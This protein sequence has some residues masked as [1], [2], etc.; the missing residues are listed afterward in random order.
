MLKH[1]SS[2]L[3]V[4]VALA[5]TA[6]GGGSGAGG[7]TPAAATGAG[8]ITPAAATGGKV[9]DG[10]L[11]GATVFCDAN[12]NGVFDA[13]ELSTKTDA[14]GNFSFNPGCNDTVVATGGIDA[15]T[16]FPFN[17]TLKSPAG[18]AMTTPVTAL[19]ADGMT[20]AQLTAALGMPAGADAT[21]SDPMLPEN[22]ALLKTT[23]AVQQIVQQ[24]A[25]TFASLA[26][27]TDVSGVYS[28]VGAALAKSLIANPS[29]SLVSADGTVNLIAINAAATDALA[30]LKTDPKFASITISAAD[31]QAATAQIGAQAQRFSTAA[32]DADLTLLAV[33]LQDPVA[34]PIDTKGTVNYLALQNDS[35]RFNG[36]PITYASLTTGAAISTPT[37]IGLDFSIQGS[38]AID[39][40]ANLALELVEVGGQSR[41]LQLMIDKVDIKNNAGQLSIAPS[42]TA[43]V[44]VYG[45]TSNG[46]DINLTLNDLTFKPITVTKNSLTLNYT[47]MVNKVLASVDN[48]TKTTAEK[49]T[50]IS[51]NF[52]ITVAV[53]GGLPIRNLDGASALSTTKVLVK[54]TTQSINGV[55]VSGTLVIQ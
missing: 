24:L 22:R 23:L 52:K 38:P 9:V 20:A 21:K 11:S 14:G 51:G 3:C 30:A 47:S 19:L 41:V 8:G 55:G 1:K 33:N 54:N 18:S 50:N 16:K 25:N 53:G 48:T 13:S 44:Y 37:T 6:C 46:T 43:K 7:T 28:K 32:V 5:L 27:S 35:I 10:Y 29:S 26:G 36:M 2:L 12:K 31:L 39:T 15:T 45:H 17:G 49:F 40:V 4:A 34:T 42:A